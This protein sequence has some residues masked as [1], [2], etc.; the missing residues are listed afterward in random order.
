MITATEKRTYLDY[1]NLPEGAPYQ[2]IDGE[3]VM[4]PSPTFDHQKIVKKLAFQLSRHVEGHQLGEVVFAP[5]DVYLSETEVYQPDIIFISN[6]RK[7]I[8]HDRIKGAPDLI[9]EVLSPSNAYY[10]L[11]H[12]KNVY[13]A[14]G[15][16]EYWIADPQERTVEVLENIGNEFRPHAKARGSGKVVSKILA[17]FELDLADLF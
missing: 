12:K 8:I 17:G 3:L 7:H 6:E 16:R 5:M 4:T 14:T 15:V 2:L 11:V 10:D 9:I 1:E 13:E